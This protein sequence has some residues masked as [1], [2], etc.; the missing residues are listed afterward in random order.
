M[1]KARTRVRVTYSRPSTESEPSAHTYLVQQIGAGL[2]ERVVRL[3]PS[4]DDADL[5][6]QRVVHGGQA[7]GDD[8]V[9]VVDGVIE[10]EQRNVVAV[11]LRQHV[12]ELRVQLDALHLE[13]LRLQRLQDLGGNDSITSFSRGH[14]TLFLPRPCPLCRTRP[15]VP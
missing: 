11:G 4:G 13:R 3:S 8:V 6:L 7:D 1:I 15:D 5:P 14:E 9:S 2:P 10:L 12:A